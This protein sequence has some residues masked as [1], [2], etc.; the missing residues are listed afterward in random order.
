MLVIIVKLKELDV[1]VNVLVKI[2]L[3]MNKIVNT[4]CQKKEAAK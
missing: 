2:V 3:S 1:Q 4:Q